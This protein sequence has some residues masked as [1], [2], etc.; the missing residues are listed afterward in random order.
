MSAASKQVVEEVKRAVEDELSMS[1]G[2]KGGNSRGVKVKRSVFTVKQI[3]EKGEISR[4]LG[5]SWVRTS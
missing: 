2:S 4:N 1:L 5:R 3:R